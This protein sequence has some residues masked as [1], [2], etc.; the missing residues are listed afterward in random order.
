MKKGCCLTVLLAWILWSGYSSPHPLLSASGIYETK[1][2]CFKQLQRQVAPL[3]NINFHLLRIMQFFGGYK[4]KKFSDGGY[5]SV[6]RDRGR[7]DALFAN[8]GITIYCLPETL[9]P[10]SFTWLRTPK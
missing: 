5:I 1:A 3:Y 6:D 7:A 8:T 4:E 2:E 9:D 10:E